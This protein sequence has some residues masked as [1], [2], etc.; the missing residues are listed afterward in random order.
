[1]SF[2]FVTHRTLKELGE[3]EELINLQRHGRLPKGQS[4]RLDALLT[5]ALLNNPPAEQEPESAA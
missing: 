2:P 5:K 3:T 1:V 4:R